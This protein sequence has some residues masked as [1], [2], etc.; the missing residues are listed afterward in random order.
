[1]NWDYESAIKKVKTAVKNSHIDNQR[2]IDLST[3]IASEREP[4]Q[5]ALAYLRSLVIKGEKTDDDLKR[6]L[7]I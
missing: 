6:D 3:V 2:H 4:T 5:A 1:M 7:G